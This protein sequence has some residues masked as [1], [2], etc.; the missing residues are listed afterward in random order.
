MTK[1][2]SYSVPHGIPSN[3]GSW[4]IDELDYDYE[5]GTLT[6]SA[7]IT[8]NSPTYGVF[9]INMPIHPDY[10]DVLRPNI[11][12]GDLVETY[13]G[14]VGLVVSVRES[15]AHFLSIKEANNKQYEV[16]I[17]DKEKTYIGYSLKKI[18]K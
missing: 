1:K 14:E 15:R 11:N 9:D 10:I 18:K 13:N 17:G 8:Y 6:A 5:Y 3:S 7:G 16:L 12:V 2:K 4:Y